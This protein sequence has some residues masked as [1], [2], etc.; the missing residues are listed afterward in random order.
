M[1]G[2]FY[3]PK[4]SSPS[5]ENCFPNNSKNLRNVKRRKPWIHYTD[6]SRL[7]VSRSHPVSLW[8][9]WTIK[10]FKGAINKIFTDRK[11][12]MATIHLQGL[13]G[14]CWSIPVSQPQLSLLRL[15]E[16]R[17]RGKEPMNQRNCWAEEKKL[18]PKDEQKNSTSD[19]KQE[20]STQWTKKIKTKQERAEDKTCKT[21]N[22]NN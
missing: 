16:L 2:E 12:Q 14:G 4:V 3:F 7:H 8:E 15:S 6:K 20:E 17:M 19:S 1:Q 21:I 10:A 22:A 13:Y 11:A 9:G 18:Q 5:C